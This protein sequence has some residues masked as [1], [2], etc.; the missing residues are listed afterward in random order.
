MIPLPDSLSRPAQQA[1]AEAGIESLEDASEWTERDVLELHGMG[2]KGI[3]SL[4]E[5]FNEHDLSFADDG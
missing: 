2:P 5:A 3:S 4:Q 1:L